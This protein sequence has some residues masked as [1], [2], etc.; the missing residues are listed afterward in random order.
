MYVCN[1]LSSLSLSLF[2]SHL[3]LST[4]NTCCITINGFLKWQHTHHQHGLVITPANS[5]LL[6]CLRVNWLGENNNNN[7]SNCLHAVTVTSIP[8]YAESKLL[9]YLLLGKYR[10]FQI[11]I[12]LLESDAENSLLLVT[13]I[14][15]CQ[16]FYLFIKKTQG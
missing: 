15:A 2:S 9:A 10:I 7:I 11:F 8:E 6:C 3:P 4:C 1:C 16:V 13:R 12:S 14:L 5:H